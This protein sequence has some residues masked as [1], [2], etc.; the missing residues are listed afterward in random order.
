MQ[1]D[2]DKRT[3]FY[4]T[5]EEDVVTNSNQNYRIPDGYDWRRNGRGRRALD[6]LTYAIAIVFS[7]IYCPIILHA[8]I[9]NRKCLRPFRRQGCF[10]YGNHT[11]MIGDAFLPA[12]ACL[13]K[14]IYVVVSPANL[15]LPVLGKVLPSLGALPIPPDVARM[16]EFN[17]S[18]DEKIAAGRCVVVYPEAHVWPYYTGIRPYSDTAFHYPVRCH[19]PTFAMTTTYQKRR[20]GKS[21]RI[22][23]YLDG[24]F[25]PEEGISPKQQRAQLCSRV[26]DSMARHSRYSDYEYIQYAKRKGNV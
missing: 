21:P 6:T 5:Y 20:F 2:R 26:Q 25:Y 15:G 13:G 10:L 4:S 19:V 18:I 14:R 23:I 24:P 17:R 16:K 1:K 22:T 12:W 9:R 8:R 3:I 11:Q 7:A